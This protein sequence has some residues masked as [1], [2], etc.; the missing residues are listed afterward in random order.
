MLKTS[1]IATGLALGVWP[2]MA[3]APLPQDKIRV[4]EDSFWR[5]DRER[6]NHPENAIAWDKPRTRPL[7]VM[8]LSD[9]AG[10]LELN[11]LNSR[12]DIDLRE[13]FAVTDNPDQKEHLGIARSTWRV[14]TKVEGYY[15]DQVEAAIR[16][17]L[18]WKPEVILIGR[19]DWM[20]LP[21]DIRQ[22][23]FELVKS[24]TGLVFTYRSARD[25]ERLRQLLEGAE[26]VPA[27]QWLLPYSEI[28]G[29]Q[30]EN[31]ALKHIFTRKHGRGT[32]VYSDWD[33]KTDP[34]VASIARYAH[35]FT[36]PEKLESLHNNGWSYEFSQMLLLKML[37]L[38]A[39]EPEGELAAIALNA[40]EFRP[41]APVTIH[42]QGEQADNV[43]LQLRRDS[44]NAVVFTRNDAFDG[45]AEITLEAPSAGKYSADVILRSGETPVDFG[46]GVF[47]VVPETEVVLT[48]NDSNAA[49]DPPEF[50]GS[51]SAP[52]ADRIRLEAWDPYGRKLAEREFPG[53]SGPWALT[54]PHPLAPGV[55]LRAAAL[56]GG[57][58]IAW[59]VINGVC[60][61]R[62]IFDREFSVSVWSYP[63]ADY[64]GSRLLKALF[65]YP[66]IG[67]YLPDYDRF[68]ADYLTTA[69][70]WALGQGASGVSPYLWRESAYAQK[71]LRDLVR[72]PCLSD[73]DYQKS[74]SAELLRMSAIARQFNPSF[75]SLGDEPYL[76]GFWDGVDGRDV[77]FSE[78]CTRDLRDWLRTR[79]DGI[80]ALN[81]A[82]GTAYADFDAIEPVIYAD[83][84]AAGNLAPWMAHRQHMVEVFM[85]ALEDA[86]RVIKSV[87]PAGLVGP[88]GMFPADPFKGYDWY[89]MGKN[90][91]FLG[92][93]GFAMDPTANNLLNSF[94]SGDFNRRI[95]ISGWYPDC[96][97]SEEIYSRFD[98]WGAFLSGQDGLL[99]W[100]ASPIFVYVSASNG[101]TPQGTLSKYWSECLEEAFHIRSRYYPL[102]Q[103]AE[104]P[105]RN[106]VALYCSQPSSISALHFTP[107]Y[108]KDLP[109]DVFSGRQWDTWLSSSGIER[110]FIAG[111]EVADGI[112]DGKEAPEVVILPGVTALTDAE[113]AA[114]ERFVGNGGTLIADL[115]PGVLD[116]NGVWRD[117][118]V[119]QAVFGVVRDGE[120]TVREKEFTAQLG[121]GSCTV[122]AWGNCRAAG[123]EALVKNGD[124]EFFFRHAYGKGR[125]YLANCVPPDYRMA[126]RAGK[127][128]AIKEFFRHYFVPAEWNAAYGLEQDHL[129]NAVEVFTF[130]SGNAG[131]LGVTRNARYALTSPEEF[132]LQLPAS[133]HIYDSRDNRYLGYGDRIAGGVS[134]DRSRLYALLPYPV[135]AMELKPAA[136]EV[137]PGDDLEVDFQLVKDGAGAWERHVAEVRVFD[138]QGELLYYRDHVPTADGAGKVMLPTAL[139]D[140]GLRR[141]RLTDCATGVSADCAFTIVPQP[142]R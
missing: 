51:F 30:T 115:E 103:G 139:N 99:M 40:A 58:E 34:A 137:I 47:T 3:D 95:S 116:E 136:A 114:L 106:R 63:A 113:I 39:G 142:T 104:R 31:G 17:A 72:K 109:V 74:R 75:Y 100:M 66:G 64:L 84:K 22:S 4:Q 11:Y 112:L 16:E 132:R 89:R 124:G 27:A 54:I 94:R 122:G 36:Y 141:I 61:D 73:P 125:A 37:Q 28:A 50:S 56:R 69:S 70:H 23:I 110:H 92:G 123:A 85:N 111:A 1:L 97:P 133:H 65:H 62:G 44:D 12:S 118:A 67:I 57:R 52:G 129:V 19:T 9:F 83:A 96:N 7:K 119:L 128:I 45:A 131:Y 14:Y 78:H 2:G 15:S 121:G 49:G 71:E 135:R 117:N 76:V 108:L 68:Q 59:S 6:P 26:A 80:A 33:E 90:F 53:D 55:E 86:A 5:V 82:W 126:A 25:D 60:P 102:L 79:Y 87:D 43:Q 38:A 13:I 98:P 127:N 29:A 140:A 48:L 18:A 21:E 91:N 105:L 42:I 35:V 41:G 8:T 134:G 10:N 32:V 77:C 130:R 107:G 138:E 120:M 81:A 101:I 93:Y 20:L 24:G 46:A 88:E